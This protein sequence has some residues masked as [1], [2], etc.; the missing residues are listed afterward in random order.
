VVNWR[1]I[2]G[3]ALVEAELQLAVVI[4]ELG[5]TSTGRLPCRRDLDA[6]ASASSSPPSVRGAPR[7]PP[8]QCVRSDLD[9]VAQ[10]QGI[11]AALATDRPDRASS[12][13]EDGAA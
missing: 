1:D 10:R 7:R 2:T 13:R 4:A 5:S 11:D 3:D 6:P 12:T 9:Q 8:V